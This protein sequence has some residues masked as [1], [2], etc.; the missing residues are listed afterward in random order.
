MK[1]NKK[2]V[3]LRLNKK[4]K[5]TFK[6]T[7]AA[8]NTTGKVKNYRKVAWESSDIRIATVGKKGKITAVGKGTCFVYAYAQNGVMA[9]I[10]V[11]VK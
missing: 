7:A 5:K 8:T 3:T 4:K 1:L 2:K 11:V 9:R 10:K 6:A